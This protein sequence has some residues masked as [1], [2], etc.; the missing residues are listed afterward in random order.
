MVTNNPEVL[1]ELSQ[2]YDQDKPI[3]DLGIKPLWTD[4]NKKDPIIKTTNNGKIEAFVLPFL[5]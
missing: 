3:I 2:E 1:E 4:E 5:P